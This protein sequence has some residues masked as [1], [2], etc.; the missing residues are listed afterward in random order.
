VPVMEGFRKSATFLVPLV[1]TLLLVTYIPELT[2][3]IPNLL[4]K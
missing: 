2:L 4:F 3:F 1:A